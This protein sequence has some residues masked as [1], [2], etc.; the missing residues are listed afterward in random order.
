MPDLSYNS[1]FAAVNG[2]RIYYEI[3]GVG[4]PFV[5][6]H[7]GVADSRQWGSAFTRFAR[8]YRVL[9][10]DLRGYGN[11]EPV[12]GEYSNLCDLAALLDDL[13]I[14]QPAILMGCSMG[15]SLALDFALA[16]PARVKALV[17]VSSGPSGLALDVPEDGRFAQAEQAYEAG[18]LDL[19][20]EIETRIWFDGVGRTP[21]QVD[22]AMRKLAYEMNRRALALEA[23]K[24]GE[25]RP[26]SETPA[27]QRLGE[28]SA[29]ALVV[30]GEHDIPYIQAAADYM[31]EKIPSARKALIRDA[32]HLP[33][34]DHPEAFRQTVEAFLA[35]IG[36]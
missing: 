8:R 32:A 3:A 14:D 5:M 31:V 19:V 22:P 12:A 30:V 33:N 27:T 36:V 28:L 34:M 11:S 1:G 21:D 7:A 6:L 15:G 10:Y 25:R 16:H 2:A 9:R 4:Q 29:L 24:L 20:A 26:D 35:Q 18:D 17:M 13:R 23:K